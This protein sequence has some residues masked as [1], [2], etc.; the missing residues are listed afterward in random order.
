MEKIPY[1]LP[2]LL[3]LNEKNLFFLQS[4]MYLP[5]LMVLLKIPLLFLSGHLKKIR[6]GWEREKEG[7][8]K[9]YPDE[10]A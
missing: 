6:G 2:T 10:A 7:R 3:L 9:M 1:T 5:A 8:K 4:C